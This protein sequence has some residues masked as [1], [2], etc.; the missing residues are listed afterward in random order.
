V[1]HGSRLG[2]S[3]RPSRTMRAPRHWRTR[4]AS[5]RVPVQTCCCAFHTKAQR[6]CAPR[7]AFGKAFARAPR[8]RRRC[9][10][11]VDSDEEEE[12]IPC[13]SSSVVRASL[14]RSIS[15]GSTAPAAV[16]AG[17]RGRA[18]DEDERI[19]PICGERFSAEAFELHWEVPPRP[20][21]P[22]T[23]QRRAHRITSPCP[24]GQRATC[25]DRAPP[26]P[27]GRGVPCCSG[28]RVAAGLARAPGGAP[29]VPRQPAAA[30]HPR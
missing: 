27:G 19:C 4:S 1:Q 15:D 14:E 8:P 29:G 30:R 7:A 28:L 3:A 23:S 5:V 12:A 24:H 25:A 22:A 16:G 11:V 26:H 13:L 2:T 17:A 10:A 9:P 20:A 21:H 18:A 6:R